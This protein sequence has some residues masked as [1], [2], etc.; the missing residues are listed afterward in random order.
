MSNWFEGLQ[1]FVGTGAFA[2]V[3]GFGLYAGLA[4]GSRVCGTILISKLDVSAH[5]H[6]HNDGGEG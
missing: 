6:I 2:L 4:L 1:I 3:I 5:T